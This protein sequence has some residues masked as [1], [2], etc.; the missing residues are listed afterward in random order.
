MMTN[1][2][3][4][5]Q[6]S[7]RMRPYNCAAFTILPALAAGGVLAFA[8]PAA[9]ADAAP[10]FGGMRPPPLAAHPSSTAEA[11]LTAAQHALL[12]TQAALGRANAALYAGNLEK[13]QAAV[14]Q[15]LTDVAAALTYVRA[16]PELNALPAGPAP[17]DTSPVR[18]AALPAGER[19]P[20]VNLMAA[21]EGLNLALNEFLNNPA[22]DYR[23]PVIGELGGFREK[24][25]ADIGSATAA[26]RAGIR[27]ASST[28]NANLRGPA[29]TQP[30]A[31]PPAPPPAS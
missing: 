8:A 24:I 3:P 6:F 20:G 31:P 25:M 17:A 26:V 5:G 15:T 4:P 23:G 14:N 27:A 10:L 18:P 12:Q 21:L 1:A 28:A 16:H 29:A 7:F 19:T 2:R 22:P 30:S 13:A 9:F 11:R